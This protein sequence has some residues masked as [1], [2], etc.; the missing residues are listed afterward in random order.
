MKHLKLFENYV[1]MNETKS[2][3]INLY[4]PKMVN[5]DV[6]DVKDIIY[7][8]MGLDWVFKMSYSP[9][10]D[11]VQRKR[12]IEKQIEDQYDPNERTITFKIT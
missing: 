4:G 8:K 11:E 5:K 12:K 6:S 7:K 10:F 3:K 2:F 9:T 1:S